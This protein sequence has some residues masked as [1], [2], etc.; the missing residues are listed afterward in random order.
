MSV[1]SSPNI[2]K[3]DRELKDTWETSWVENS[4]RLDKTP[5]LFYSCLTHTTP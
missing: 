3:V 1:V 4:S 5:Q 2:F